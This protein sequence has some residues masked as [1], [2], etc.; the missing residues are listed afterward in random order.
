M[1]KELKIVSASG[2]P[3]EEFEKLK[4]NL[5]NNCSKKIQLIQTDNIFNESSRENMLF[6]SADQK[7]LDLAAEYGIAAVG[8]QPPMMREMLRANMVVEG[9]DE[10][11]AVFLQHVFERHW[12]IGWTILETKRC[13]V[14]EL[15]LADL[16]ALFEMYAEAGMTDYIEALYDY[17]KEKQYQKAYIEHMY[18]FYGYG[19]WLVFDKQSNQLIGRAGLEH[20][21][22]LN[23]EMELGY[24]IRTSCQRQGYAFEV[25]QAIVSYAK[26]ELGVLLLHCLI[27]KENEASKHLA[28]KLGFFFDREREINGN[29]MSDYVKKLGYGIKS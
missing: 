17:E 12:G 2:L 8:Y 28:Q 19:L 14:R 27:K 1:R 23:G 21:E 7:Q 16:D 24:A 26:E 11:D 6:I 15:E 9:F 10:V 18:G 5:Q 25:C 29:L 4:Q 22:E 13:I 20:R 3:A